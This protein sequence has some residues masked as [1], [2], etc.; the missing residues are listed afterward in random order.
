MGQAKVLCVL[1]HRSGE[2]R[3]TGPLA[4]KGCL[5]AH[6]NCLLY[7][8]G[9]CC[10][11]SPEFD[12]LF[13]FSVDDVTDEVKRGTKLWC[14]KCKKKGATA[15]CER[16]QCKKSFH[17][18]CAIEKGAVVIEDAVKGKYGLFCSEHCQA[19]TENKKQSTA[20]RRTSSF[21]ELEKP[22]NH[23]NAASPNVSCLTSLRPKE[24]SSFKSLTNGTVKLSCEKHKSSSQRETLKSTDAV[25]G[26]SSSSDFPC[27][28]K[29]SSSKRPSNSNGKEEE[30]PPKRRRN[31]WSRIIPDDS[32]SD[33]DEAATEVHMFAPLELDLDESANSNPEHQTVPQITRNDAESP[34]ASTSGNHVVGQDGGGHE[35]EDE[36]LIHSDAESESLL[37]PVVICMESDTSQSIESS[38][39][40]NPGTCN[41]SIH[42][43]GPHTSRPSNP[44]EDTN[45][46]AD[47]PPCPSHS[48]PPCTSSAI[49]SAPPENGCVLPLHNPSPPMPTQR[50]T[51]S[52]A[53]VNSIPDPEFDCA[54]FWKCCNKARCTQ[55]IF[56]DFISE[57]N[58]IS[59]RIQS[60]Q[61]SQEDYK[62]ALRVMMASGKLTELIVKQQEDLKQKQME[63]QKAALAMEKVMSALK[64]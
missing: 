56:S 34:I 21:R 55:A 64:S 35:E 32:D 10:E 14:D 33:Q 20:C 3:I 50:S 2:T 16:R 26:T 42:T 41:G 48:N 9:I 24:S 25:A 59:N 36:T 53:F 11:N 54:S 46:L 52:P 5:T 13:G 38:T 31:E 30:S 15:G 44:H 40:Q 17:Y 8:S 18:P 62:L 45:G 7:S 39:G 19:V 58:N 43:A 22:K 27:S 51:P 12:D 61:A 1:C 4:T 28:F 63:L 37:L 49:S 60:D 47:P 29:S 57:M 23:S 6:Q